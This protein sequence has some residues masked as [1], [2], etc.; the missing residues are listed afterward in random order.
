[1]FSD[2]NATDEAVLRELNEAGLTKWYESR[3]ASLDAVIGS[4]AKSL[5]GG[6]ERRL[7]LARTL[8]RGAGFVMLDEPTTG[9]DPESRLAAEKTIENIECDILLVA[10]HEYSPEF[11]EHF[12]RVIEVKN[13]EIYER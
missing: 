13:G 1:M 9:L 2:E 3:G 5:S 10:M 6:E 11:L 8:H 4:S 12:N 7:D